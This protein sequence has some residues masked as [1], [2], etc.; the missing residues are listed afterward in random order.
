MRFDILHNF[1]SPV[2]GRV[3]SNTD[4]VLVGDRLE[5]A[6]PSPILI[7]IKLDLDNLRQQI[8]DVKL[9]KLEYKQIWT[10]NS[11]NETITTTKID[12]D[13]LPDLTSNKV[14]KGNAQN[15][16]EE[17]EL[18][19]APDYATYITQSPDINL[20]NAQALSLLGTGMAKVITGGQIAIATPDIDYATTETLERIRNEAGAAAEEATAAAAEATGAAA[21]AT[22]AAA[23]A[24]IAAGISFFG[25]LDSV[26]GDFFGGG[27]N[28]D[29]INSDSYNR[30]TEQIT[31]FNETIIKASRDVLLYTESATEAAFFA[32][33]YAQQV[34]AYLNQINNTD[35]TLVGDVTGSGPFDT[36]INTTFKE[37]PK[38]YGL[39]SIQIP[40][41]NSAERPSVSHI[42]MIR[43]NTD[44]AAIEYYNNSIW[45]QLESNSIQIGLPYA[46][47]M[48]YGVINNVNGIFDG[49][50]SLEKDLDIKI[51]SSYYT[52]KLND[53]S[54]VLLSLLNRYNNGYI[55]KT[56]SS[57]TG[58]FDYLLQQQDSGLK[59]DLLK[60]D[61]KIDE[62]V[63]HKPIS[64]NG[65]NI[66]KYDEAVDI[67]T[68][69][70]NNSNGLFSGFVTDAQENN[71]KI[72]SSHFAANDYS[73][74]S[75]SFLNRYNNGYIFSNK[76]H[77]DWSN[78]F[79]FSGI[80]AEVRDE[81]FKYDPLT[82]KF[83]FNKLVEVP[84]PIND[85]DAANKYYVDNAAKEAYRMQG[86]YFD[87]NFLYTSGDPVIGTADPIIV[88]TP[89]INEFGVYLT[90]GGYDVGN[91]AR[92][93][94]GGYLYVNAEQ[95][96]IF[97]N[98][99]NSYVIAG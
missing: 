55:N 13:N 87:N 96:L 54:S 75:L 38:F 79:S 86:I 59:V 3:L 1:I 30:T 25:G 91:V 29:I 2:T 77:S 37:N 93:N 6:T 22:T 51:K 23:E 49:F 14:W 92:K 32:E 73:T 9:P 34:E 95:Q 72:K 89:L 50:A 76:T 53:S 35:I 11:N 64:Y 70:L 33:N 69:A 39:E 63:F 36:P 46:T 47:D 74:S 88:N 80:N 10:G 43:Y 57:N 81:L 8:E 42:G 71:I 94:D 31:D 83:I 40:F 17:A 61:N 98:A 65:K 15:R 5:I 52:G 97:Q 99:T 60:F 44:Y 48:V 4:Y 67:V 82:S 12:I 19:I 85:A 56:I 26:L 18:Q 7:D 24:S 62:F 84:N 66:I 68:G 45:T 28:N 58:Y 27:G 41:G 78:E 90:Y 16:P 20:P 21:E